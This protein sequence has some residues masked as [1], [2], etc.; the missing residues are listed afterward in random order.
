MANL[1]SPGTTETTLRR[2]VNILFLLGEERSV[3]RGG[4]GVAQI[5]AALELD[6]GQVSRTLRTLDECGA[7]SRDHET[8]QYR[9]SWRLYALAARAG[10]DRLVATAAPVMQRLREACQE[11]V[12]LSVLEGCEVLT[13][14]SE[15]AERVVQSTDMAGRLSPAY[16]SSAGRALLFDHSRDALDGIFAGVK[17]QQLAPRTPTSLAEMLDRLEKDRAQGVSVVVEEYEPGLVGVAAPVRDQG[18][19]IVAALNV[20]APKYRMLERTEFAAQKVCE[21]SDILSRQLGYE[22]LSD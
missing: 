15:V 8:L 7:V 21:S 4:L 3:R 6:K 12:Y 17:F 20:S 13:V 10:T 11:T 9:L 14:R 19:R 16:C 18:G 2:G 1:E 22:G 5:A